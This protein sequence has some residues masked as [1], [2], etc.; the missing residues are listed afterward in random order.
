MLRGMLVSAAIAATAMCGGCSN[1]PA[2]GVLIPV[3][4]QVEGTAR[5]PILVATA[6]KKTTDLD[7]CSARPWGIL[8]AGLRASVAMRP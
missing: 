6:R 1:R 2:Q 8:D 4:D 3:K 7:S 5:V